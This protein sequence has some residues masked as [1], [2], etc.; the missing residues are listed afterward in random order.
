MARATASIPT[1]TGSLVGRSG[2]WGIGTG[3]RDGSSGVWVEWRAAS[4][5]TED[6]SVGIRPPP[7][8]ARRGGSERLEPGVVVAVTVP[9]AL[10]PD[11]TV[12][13]IPYDARGRAGVDRLAR[14]VTPPGNRGIAYLVRADETTWPEGAYRFRIA[15]ATRSLSID[16]CLVAG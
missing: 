9:V 10:P 6:R 1:I 11:W 4:P 7:S 5:A 2:E 15:T 16:A 13:A 12:E 3:G 8:C 14:Q